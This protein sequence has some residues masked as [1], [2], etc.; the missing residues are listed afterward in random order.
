MEWS[1]I[2]K[3]KYLIES[4]IDQKVTKSVSNTRLKKK[5]MIWFSRN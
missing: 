5:K 1:K 2:E 4:E 3:I